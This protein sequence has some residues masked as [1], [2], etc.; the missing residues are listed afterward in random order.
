MTQPLL[1]VKVEFDSEA[2]PPGWAVVIG[3]A[4]HGRWLR[5]RIVVITALPADQ[6]KRV[7]AAVEAAYRAGKAVG[8]D[9]CV[10]RLT[11]AGS[12][13]ERMAL[14]VPVVPLT[15]PPLEEA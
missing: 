5:D 3:D 8:R 15:G 7:A 4:T 1:D 6:A 11:Q 12:N 10:E 14:G 13:Q 9:W 2:E